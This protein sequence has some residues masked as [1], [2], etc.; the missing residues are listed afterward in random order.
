MSANTPTYISQ[1]ITEIGGGLR[2]RIPHISLHCF[3]SLNMPDFSQCAFRVLSPSAIIIPHR[4]TFGNI[5]TY[6]HAQ[7]RATWTLQ[8]HR[9]LHAFYTRVHEREGR[10]RGQLLI[11]S[12]VLTR[13]ENLSSDIYRIL[14]P[15]PLSIQSANA[16]TPIGGQNLKLRP[17]TPTPTENCHIINY[18]CLF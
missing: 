15:G 11:P 7:L 9:L 18:H 10:R 17:F 12:T 3:T 13:D 16:L 14:N 6:R 5:T 8:S 2:D 4:L 1:S